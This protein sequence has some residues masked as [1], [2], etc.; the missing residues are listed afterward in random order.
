MP[1]WHVRDSLTLFYTILWQVTVKTLHFL[2]SVS[3]TETFKSVYSHLNPNFQDTCRPLVPHAAKYILSP[4]LVL[5]VI[6]PI[7]F[8]QLFPSL[9][10]GTQSKQTS[11]SG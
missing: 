2:D 7:P 3:E 8:I 1:A 6:F 11:L 4:S 9:C 5:Q 10:F